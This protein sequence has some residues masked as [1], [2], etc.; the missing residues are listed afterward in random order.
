MAKA[1]LTALKAGFAY[2]EAAEIFTTLT[3]VRKPPSRQANIANIPA[4]EATAL[5]FVAASVLAKRPPVLRELPDHTGVRYFARAID[6]KELRHQDLSSRRRNCGGVRGDRRGVCRPTRADRNERTGSGTEERS[7]RA[8]GDDRVAHRDRRRSTRRAVNG[9]QTRP[10]KRWLQAM[11]EDG[12]CRLR[13][14]GGNPGIVSYGHR[15][16]ACDKTHAA[17]IL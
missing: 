9:L 1:N 11:V 12:E 8:R 17:V 6:S 5:G 13:R 15:P 3:G 7:D 2:A 14:G 4:N 10:S 16:F